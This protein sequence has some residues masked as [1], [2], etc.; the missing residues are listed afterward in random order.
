MR[1][2]PFAL[3]LLSSS[4][5]GIIIAYSVFALFYLH[6][7]EI[8]VVVRIVYSLLICVAI[9]PL[10]V[11]MDLEALDS[12]FTKI[13]FHEDSMTVKRPFTRSLAIPLDSISVF[14]CISYS[15]RGTMLFF[16][17]DSLAVMH[18][19][20]EQNWDRCTHIYGS[21]KTTEMKQS[22]EGLNHLAIGT[23]L[24]GYVFRK[25]K[26]VFVLRYGSMK[27]LEKVVSLFKRD[28]IITGPCLV[29]SLSKLKKYAIYES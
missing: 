22:D 15:P 3:F 5:A 6:K 20:L 21:N 27:R 4:L 13:V 1:G 25:S 14:G 23:Y 2:C 16:S 17:T 10:G 11:L 19:Y 7:V 24:H 29:N 8:P 18:I 9:L 28:A 26:N 12:F